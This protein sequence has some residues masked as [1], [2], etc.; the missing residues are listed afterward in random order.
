M[1]QEENN[2]RDFS[3]LREI[4]QRFIQNNAVVIGGVIFI[5]IFYLLFFK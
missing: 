1:N 3:E 2:S 4:G 5:L